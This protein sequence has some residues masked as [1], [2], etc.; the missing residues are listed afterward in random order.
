MKFISLGAWIV[1]ALLVMAA[2]DTQPDPPALNPSAAA[3]K[4]LQLHDCS[5]GPA[6]QVCD[7]FV[8]AP[9][10]SLSTS[11]VDPYEYERPVDSTSLTERA[12]DSSPPRTK[13]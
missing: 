11:D 3:C 4:A 1:G 10:L 13:A 8:A 7:S 12:A 2:L 5:C 9:A 6:P